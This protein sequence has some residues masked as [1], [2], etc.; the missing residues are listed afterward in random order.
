MGFVTMIGWTLGTTTAIMSSILAGFTVDYVVHL[1]HAYVETPGD[2]VTKIRAS[3]AEMGGSVFSGML[4][5][6]VASL[7]LFMCKIKFF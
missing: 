5:S 2:T 4:T 1:A 7:P 3:F 6:V